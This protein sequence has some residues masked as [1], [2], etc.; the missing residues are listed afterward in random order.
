MYCFLFQR[1]LGVL[2]SQWQAFLRK[3][4]HVEY[5]WLGASVL[6]V[7]D[8]VHHLYNSLA[9]MHGFLL[10]I[11]SDDGQL[12]L[13]QHAVVHDGVVVPA[14]FLAGREHV[15]DGHITAVVPQNVRMAASVHS[16]LCFIS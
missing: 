11:L 5:D 4:E 1:N 8:G 9:F 6:A 7:V 13:Y 3:V 2:D 15:L 16:L 14:Q 12:A 10:A